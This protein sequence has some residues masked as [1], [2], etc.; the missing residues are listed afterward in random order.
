MAQKR[1]FL[2]P[3]VQ[4]TQFETE[5]MVKLYQGICFDT[6]LQMKIICIG[7]VIIL[8]P[9]LAFYG[10]KNAIFAIQKH[11]TLNFET[12]IMVKMEETLSNN[13]F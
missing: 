7:S 6:A 4:N 11:K 2:P 9:F 1:L 5:N 10:P 12:E 13:V 8:W 3:E